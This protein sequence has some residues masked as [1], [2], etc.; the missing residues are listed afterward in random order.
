MVFLRLAFKSLISRRGSVVLTCLAMTVSIFVI[1]GVEHIRNQAKES[2]YNTVSGADL[3][4][5]AR[6]GS[7]NLL[8]YS[9]F[10]IGSATNNVSWESYLDITADE[11][12]K[13]AIPISLGDSHM[14]YRVMGTTL[15]YFEHFSYGKKRNLKFKNGKP[16]NDLFEV[17][18]GAQV[19]KK[20]GYE[21][22]DRITL[23]HGIGKTS[24]SMHDDKPFRVSG[25]LAPTGT[26]VDQ[27]LHVS[28]QGIEAIHLDW[29]PGSRKSEQEV[30]PIKEEDLAIQSV[31][32][33]VLGLKSRMTTFEVQR[34]I[35]E[36]SQEPLLA[37]LPGVALAQLWEMI[38]ILEGV[39]QLISYLILFSSLLGLAA[40]LLASMRER[41]QEIKLFRAIGASPG[42]LFVLIQL[43]ALIIC[44]FSILIGSACLLL[45]LGVT[46]EMLSANFGL[47]VEANIFSINSVLLLSLVV[48][49][50]FAVASIPSLGAY[51]QA[52]SVT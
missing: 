49:A 6:T 10:R 47:Y 46:K 32:A 50:T 11:R 44:G 8:L 37:I 51:K 39:L 28:L 27:T 3:I 29:Q 9:V 1:L 16:F 34:E 2:F 26:P 23:A 18:L 21:I 43:E 36:Y 5:G 30:K 45:C 24:F 42:F 40:M 7:T 14:G 13:W 25:I 15:S 12:V 22:G 4:V 41:E 31:T 52:R 17:V 35:N 48:I 20:L 19:A 33:F 38:N